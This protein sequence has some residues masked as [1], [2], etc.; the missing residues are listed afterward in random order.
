M[1]STKDRTDARSRSVRTIG[2]GLVSTL[3]VAVAA[4]VLDQVTPGEIVDYATLGTAAATA[5]GTALCAYL[6]RILEGDRKPPATE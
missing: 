2:Q 1:A 6:Q 5:M 3:L 4:V